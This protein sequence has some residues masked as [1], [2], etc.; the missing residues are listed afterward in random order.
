MTRARAHAH[1][2]HS[3]IVV[4]DGFECS[5]RNECRT[6]RQSLAEYHL[7]E[8]R[9]AAPAEYP[10]QRAATS[11]RVMSR[12]RTSCP[13]RS[14]IDFY[15]LLSRIPASIHLTLEGEVAQHLPP[16][17]SERLADMK[18]GKRLPFADDRS[19]CPTGGETW[20]LLRRPAHRRQWLHQSSSFVAPGVRHDCD[21]AFGVRA[22]LLG[23]ND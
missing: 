17:S 21:A 12:A 6:S 11:H 4:Q 3:S 16:R 23:P 9:C 13:A 15:T 2:A 1:A 18:P 19:G 20:R 22:V 14:A 8:N 5:A 7:V 10:K